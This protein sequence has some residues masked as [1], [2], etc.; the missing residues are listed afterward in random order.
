MNATSFSSRMFHQCRAEWRHQYGMVLLWLAVLVTRQ[1]HRAHE[2][3]AVFSKL[4]IAG[5]DLWLEVGALLMAAA[6]A[7]RSVSADTPSN[8]DTFSL[9]RPVGQ[10]ALWCGKLL[11]LLS[12]VILPTALVVS[13]SWQGF[14]L[15]MGQWTAM[16]GAVLL[17]GGLVCG[18]AGTLTAL[19]STTRQVFALAVL[20]VIGA[21]IE[22]VIPGRAGNQEV[23]TLEQHHVELCGSFVA[24]VSALAG[25]LGAWWLAT[26][27]RMRWVAACCMSGTLVAAPLIADAWRSDWITP[28]AP[29]HANAEKLSLKVGKADPADKAPGRGLWPTL[30]ITGLGKDEVASIAEFAPMDDKATWPPEGSYSDLKV[31]DGGFDSW[32]HHEHTRALFKHSPA[33][34]LWRQQ[35]GNNGMHNS[36]PSL[37]EVMQG[38]RLKREDAITRRWRLR[39]V[40]HEMKRVATLPFRQF[41]TQENEFLIRPGLRLEFNAFDWLREAW[42]MHGRA[43]RLHSSVLS[44]DAHRFANVR[45]RELSDDFFLVLEDLE[46]KEN[47]ALSLGLV[48]REKQWSSYRDRSYQ[49]QTDENQG[50]TIRM[51][52]PRE[53]EVILKRTRDEWIDAQKA[54]V[55]HAEERGVVEFELTAAQMAEVLPEPVKKDEKKP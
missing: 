21:G 4:S 2:V 47:K 55:W 44:A 29:K 16:T 28:P 31:N 34:T 46:L 20:A 42:E 8:T 49:W 27:P 51:W 40:V 12:A 19:T 53:Q 26:V 41:W 30:R 37:N 32:L 11:F 9:T 52:T 45:G 24:A 7:W 23:I 36:R 22:L 1:W 48:Q 43:H 10:A 3:K 38:L 50:F 18:I 35:I 33:T 54:S 5:F 14:G 13:R 25:L 17:T 6:L 15:G 39:L